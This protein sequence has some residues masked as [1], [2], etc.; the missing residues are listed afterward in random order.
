MLPWQLL[1]AQPPGP[2]YFPTGE[3][4]PAAAAAS[5]KPIPMPATRRRYLRPV[6]ARVGVPRF[7]IERYRAM[8]QEIEIWLAYTHSIPRN[9]LTVWYVGKTAGHAPQVCAAGIPERTFAVTMAGEGA[10]L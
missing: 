5:M 4:W 6:A 10:T 3:V 2:L 7:M 9:Q 1:E 8:I